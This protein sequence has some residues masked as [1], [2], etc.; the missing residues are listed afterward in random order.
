MLIVF[1]GRRRRSKLVWMNFFER[2]EKKGRQTKEI[3]LMSGFRIEK[4]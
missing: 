3:E 4:I 2:S 1:L